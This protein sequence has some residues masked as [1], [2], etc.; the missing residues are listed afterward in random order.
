MRNYKK[1]GFLIA[2]VA[3]IAGTTFLSSCGVYSFRDVSIPDT[4]KSV[5]IA[6]IV[7]RA[8]YVNTQLAGNLTDRLRRKIQN[9]TRLRVSNDPG[10]DL[11]VNATITDY[12][13]STSG[14]SSTGA[15][16]NRLTVTVQV[17]VTK[18]R[19]PAAPPQEYTLS[20][21]FDFQAT[22]SLQDAE[23]ELFEEIVRGLTDDIFNRLFSNW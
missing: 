7:N 12:S 2:I 14:V 17:S 13:L 16:L 15:S 22:K 23:R 20:R 18:G 11:V 19:D 10:A 3:L 1:I 8:P 5:Q 21:P 6:P 9:Q 4:V